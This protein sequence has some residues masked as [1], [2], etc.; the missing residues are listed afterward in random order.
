MENNETFNI[1]MENF[2][3]NLLQL[4]NTT[5]EPQTTEQHEPVKTDL[6]QNV[7]NDLSSFFIFNENLNNSTANTKKRKHVEEEPTEVIQQPNLLDYLIKQKP[8]EE[9]AS[10]KFL[11]N[12]TDYVLRMIKYYLQQKEDLHAI[13]PEFLDL[14]NTD[15]C[16]REDVLEMLTI[17]KN[18]NNIQET[19]Q[20]SKFNLELVYILINNVCKNIAKKFPKYES[21]ILVLK[22]S[23]QLQYQNTIAKD[24]QVDALMDQAEHA[25]N[26]CRS[27]PRIVNQ[28]TRTQDFMTNAFT[29]VLIHFCTTFASDVLFKPE[30]E[31]TS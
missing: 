31:V 16:N 29:P 3:P 11:K 25:S 2:D 17:I 13:F 27:K 7:E 4:E 23:V 20:R 19:D 28:F 24:Y 30:S 1:N 22:N 12:K 5:V 6:L 14:V 15:S 9:A 8:K 10:S 18:V 26:D 21:H